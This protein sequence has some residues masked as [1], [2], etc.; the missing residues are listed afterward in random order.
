MRIRLRGRYTGIYMEQAHDYQQ[1]D[2]MV[3]QQIVDLVDEP[4][5]LLRTYVLH[6]V[7]D[8]SSSSFFSGV[9]GPRLI[10]TQKSRY[11]SLAQKTETRFRLMSN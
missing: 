6:E 1:R 7:S 3:E 8:E 5:I 11:N 2:A 9:G 4:C 10:P